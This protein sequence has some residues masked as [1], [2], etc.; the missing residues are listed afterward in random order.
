MAFETPFLKGE[1]REEREGSSSAPATDFANSWTVLVSATRCADPGLKSELEVYFPKDYEGKSSF[2]K[3]F[4]AHQAASGGEGKNNIGPE[5]P[6]P[7]W[8]MN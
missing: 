1:I 4:P 3:Q 8:E 6:P 5:A 2:R 7:E